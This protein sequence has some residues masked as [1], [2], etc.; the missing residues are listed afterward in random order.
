VQGVGLYIAVPA[1]DFTMLSVHVTM[2]LFLAVPACDVAV[3]CCASPAAA[4]GAGPTAA[5][6]TTPSAST[7]TSAE[8]A[9]HQGPIMRLSLRVRS[10]RLQTAPLTQQQEEDQQQQAT[11]TRSTPTISAPANQVSHLGS[12]QQLAQQQQQRQQHQSFAVGL[13][14]LIASDLAGEN[15]NG[16]TGSTGSH[17]GAVQEQPPGS[18]V[19]SGTAASPVHSS[20]A[21]VLLRQAVQGAQQQYQADYPAMMDGSPTFTGSPS[22]ASQPG[23]PGFSNM[24]ARS[25]A[26]E[27]QHLQVWSSIETSLY[28][29]LILACS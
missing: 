10:E 22:W 20:H 4:P 1:S 13:E 3:A 12:Q 17:Q 15:N 24:W 23:T 18:T 29:C 7:S 19:Q 26:E 21:S 25:M 11:P 6:T 14:S 9:P 2:L 5:S 8:G 27:L 16:S 28:R